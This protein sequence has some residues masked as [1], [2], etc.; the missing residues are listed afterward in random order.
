MSWVP[1]VEEKRHFCHKC[2]N[3]L[4]FD[5]KLQ[6]YKHPDGAYRGHEG[7]IMLPDALKDVVQAVLGLDNRPQARPNFR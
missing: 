5:V 6:R 2:K 1:K 3:E 4:K 7:Q